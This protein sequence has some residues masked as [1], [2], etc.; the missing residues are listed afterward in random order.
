MRQSSTGPV[1]RSHT[2]TIALYLSGMGYKYDRSPDGDTFA[3]SLLT[4]TGL[5]R[6]GQLAIYEGSQVVR[7]FIRIPE[8]Y[9]AKNKAAWV[10]SLIAEANHR[11]A[12]L[13]WFA[14][15]A[16]IGVYYQSAVRTN[17][18][19]DTDLVEQ[20]MNSSAFPLAVFERA[21]RSAKYRKVTPLD[22]LNASLIEQNVSEGI[23]VGKGTRRA[24]MRVLK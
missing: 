11:L 22:A 7:S 2:D 20:L 21:L 8:P 24:L 6:E 23:K 9:A 5:L 17:G 15:G 12:V 19:V 4:D 1:P 3:F 14:R 16:P 18:N 13:G 10:D